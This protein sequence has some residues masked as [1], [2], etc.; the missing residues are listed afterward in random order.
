MSES[1]NPLSYEREEP[2]MDKRE[3]RVEWLLPLAR[4]LWKEKLFPQQ[5]VS[6]LASE[7]Q[8]LFNVSR[9]TAEGYA[10][11]AYRLLEAESSHVEE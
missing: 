7:A 5:I 8:K 9:S 3:E 1:L 6:D 10:H 11:A 4:R 2:K